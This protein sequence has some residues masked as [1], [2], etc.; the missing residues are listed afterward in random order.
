MQRRVCEGV[1]TKLD[2]G[3]ADK[4]VK[5]FRFRGCK[6]LVQVYRCAECG[7]FH[8]GGI[9]GWCRAAQLSMAQSVREERRSRRIRLGRD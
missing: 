4:I 1:K 8:V 6:G 5:Q 2:F 3:L 7:H 9:Q